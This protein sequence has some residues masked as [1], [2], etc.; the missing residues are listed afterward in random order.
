MNILKPDRG[1]PRSYYLFTTPLEHFTGL[2]LPNNSKSCYLKKVGPN[3]GREWRRLSNAARLC[4]HLRQFISKHQVL[5]TATAVLR[6]L[7]YSHRCT[8]SEA[9]GVRA[10]R[11]QFPEEGRRTYTQPCPSAPAQ[12]RSCPEKRLRSRERADAELPLGGTGRSVATPPKHP[13]GEGGRGHGGAHAQVVFADAG[14]RWRGRRLCPSKVGAGWTRTC[15]P[16]WRSSS[17]ARVGWASPGEAV[18][19]GPSASGL[20][21][22]LRNGRCGPIGAAPARPG[23]RFRPHRPGS[24]QLGGRTWAWSHR[25]DPDPA[26]LLTLSSPA[27]LS[28]LESGQSVSP[29]VQLTFNGRV[30]SVVIPGAEINSNFITLRFQ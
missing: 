19:G 20:R 9:G 22:A 24:S 7:K 15:W 10:G 16:L 26:G 12:R 17:S 21:A 27:C 2:S 14:E 4:L 13:V 3:L 1:K 28:A 18:R 6:T 29:R 25:D 5:P 11:S 23:A 8:K 30:Q